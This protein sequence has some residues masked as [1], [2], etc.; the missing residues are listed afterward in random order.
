MLYWRTRPPPPCVRGKEEFNPTLSGRSPHSLGAPSQEHLV[1]NRRNRGSALQENP[2]FMRLLNA[3]PFHL[4]A[5]E[6][7]RREYR[8]KYV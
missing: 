2:I 1:W 6:R 8:E 7:E 3:T 4:A 5:V